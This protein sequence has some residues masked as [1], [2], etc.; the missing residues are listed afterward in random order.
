MILLMLT[1]GFVAAGLLARGEAAGADARAYWA[2]V[3]IW[4]NGGDPYNPTG[5]FLPYIY[6]PW[7]LPL[8]A[9]WALLPWDVAWFV[10]RAGA[11]L[12]LLWS[13]DWAYRRRPLETAVVIA[14]LGFPIGANL[15]LGNITLLLALALFGAQFVGPRLAGLLWALSAWMKWLPA[16][17]WLVLAPRARAW[18]LAWLAVAV[19]LTLAMLPQT[20]AQL[21]AIFG[22]GPRPIRVDYLVLLWALVPWLWR[23]PEP[24]DW[25]HAGFWRRRIVGWRADGHAWLR[26]TRT[27]PGGASIAR[28][29]A[30]SWVR[31]FLGLGPA[32][33]ASRGPGSSSP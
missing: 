14:L 33:S 12:A 27:E 24:F 20:L 16:A 5:P 3:R 18:G 31:T 15:D 9:P 10:W 17:L 6:T 23:R 8:F 21:D 26:R 25:I 29:H 22:F 4:L 11:I 28:R 1:F 19:V 32:T 13:I 2:G 7:M 30:V